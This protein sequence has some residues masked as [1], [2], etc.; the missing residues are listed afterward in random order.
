MAAAASWPAAAVEN[1]YTAASN[2]EIPHNMLITRKLHAYPGASRR[3]A[4]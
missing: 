3:V 4:T 2:L 1:L